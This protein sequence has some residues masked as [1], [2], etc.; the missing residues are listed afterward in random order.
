MK[1][2]VTKE[3][4]NGTK[5]IEELTEADFKLNLSQ[6]GV[7]MRIGIDIS[8]MAFKKQVTQIILIA[9]DSDFV[10]AAKQA[11]REGVDSQDDRIAQNIQAI[12]KGVI[13][14]EI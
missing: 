8:S 12:F 1:P 14:G 6:K 2:E 7:D 11:R 13:K 10:P 5:K 3:L 9:G 4:L